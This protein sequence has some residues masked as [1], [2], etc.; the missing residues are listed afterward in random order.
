MRTLQ[1]L[2][3]LCVLAALMVSCHNRSPLV[4]TVPLGPRWGYT[5]STCRFTAGSDDPDNDALYIRFAWGDGDTTDW[6][7]QPRSI[8]TLGA[9]H[10]WPGPGR[11]SVRAQAKDG[12]G[13]ETE[14]SQATEVLIDT[15]APWPT[16]VIAEV[17]VDSV[18]YDVAVAPDGQHLF[19]AC[20]DGG[21]I[22]VVRTSD[23]TVTATVP[24][25][26]HVTHLA[27]S[28]DGSR[29]YVGTTA[30]HVYVVSTA[31]NAVTDSIPTNTC[32]GWVAID[33]AGA[34][35]YIGSSTT[36]GDPSQVLKVRTADNAVVDSFNLDQGAEALALKPDGTGL[37]VSTVS[38]RVRLL[39][40]DTLRLLDTLKGSW[41][42][43]PLLASDDGTELYACG[44]SN[45]GRRRL[46][47]YG[48]L[49]NTLKYTI[50]LP[51]A[52]SLSEL[53]GFGGG[54]LLFATGTPDLFVFDIGL[55]A[56]VARLAFPDTR[57]IAASEQRHE[58][59]FTDEY[60]NKLIVL[61]F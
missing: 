55:R 43:A 28:P 59:Y 17:P 11:Y 39:A 50:G 51:G 8:D 49:D 23:W 16:R 60:E 6:L 47:V 9:D 27:V 26:E 33:R 41:A 40:T 29:L 4:P 22:S 2:I 10:V 20:Y 46:D 14:W 35:L 61:G 34:F 19:V 21:S 56:V 24:V 52:P 5:D 42:T 12:H 7:R 15:F 57:G 30:M 38:G 48:T 44:L 1:R 37:Y 53:A 25:S 32:P 36:D 58:V 13:L 45:E 31:T 3:G 18:P 54:R